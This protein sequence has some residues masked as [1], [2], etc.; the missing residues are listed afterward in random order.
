MSVPMLTIYESDSSQ[1]TEVFGE[2]IGRNLLGGE[3]IE[4]VSDLGG[5]KTTITRGIARGAGSND[6]VGS[7]T[8]MISKIY[9]T[10]GFEIHHFDFYRLTEIGQ[11]EHELHEALADKNIVVI[12]EWGEIVKHV[13]PENRLTINIKKTSEESRELKLTC[14]T[15]LAYLVENT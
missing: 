11:I 15:K 1:A 7:P 5:G 13:L 12:V 6:V 3:V 14:P 8:F 9:Q 10:Q 2:Q 4:L